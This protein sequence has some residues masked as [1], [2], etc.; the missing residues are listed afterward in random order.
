MNTKYAN[1][2]IKGIDNGSID[3]DD[4]KTDFNETLYKKGFS[5]EEVTEYTD[6]NFENLLTF[7]ENEKNFL[8]WHNKQ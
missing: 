7:E 1:K 4:L 6:E 5:F 2:I 3:A 8:K